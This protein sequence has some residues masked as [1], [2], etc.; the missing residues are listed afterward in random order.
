MSLFYRFVSWATLHWGLFSL[1]CTAIGSVVLVV[2]VRLLNRSRDRAQILLA[3]AQ[4][5]RIEAERKQ[6]EID[7]RISDG[8]ELLIIY[9]EWAKQKEGRSRPFSED[10]IRDHLRDY[11]DLYMAI[12]TSMVEKGKAEK[13]KPGWWS[14][15]E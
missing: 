10:E 1:G 11:A 14:I 6:A 13:I 8:R 7:N 2:I 15:D 5:E 4:R 9:A 12:M 3:N